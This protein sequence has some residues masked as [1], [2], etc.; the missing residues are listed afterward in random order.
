MKAFSRYFM[1]F[2]FTRDCF[3]FSLVSCLRFSV[4]LMRARGIHILETKWG[5]EQNRKKKWRKNITERESERDKD[6]WPSACDIKG[7]FDELKWGPPHLLC[8]FCHISSPLP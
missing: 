8:A 7:V 6:G 3:T 2:N 1:I 4:P 5:K